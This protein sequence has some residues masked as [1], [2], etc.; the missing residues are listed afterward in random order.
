MYEQEEVSIQDNEIN[1]DNESD[2]IIIKEIPQEI[3]EDEVECKNKS[4]INTISLIKGI[5]AFF[6]VLNAAKI[7]APEIIPLPYS[8]MIPIV[9]C[10]CLTAFVTSI[11]E[12][13]RLCFYKTE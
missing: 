4:L 12:N 2:E 7:L 1:A 8:G 13:T 5:V 10:V 6:F 3:I 11:I 9:V